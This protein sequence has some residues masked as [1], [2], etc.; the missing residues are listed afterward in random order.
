MITIPGKIEDNSFDEIS[1]YIYLI[2][3]ENRKHIA[4]D[5]SGSYKIGYSN[6]LH[7]RV[8]L[9][10]NEHQ[11]P[12]KVIAYGLS[13]NHIK[14][15]AH[16]HTLFKQHR[17]YGEY[18]D[19][20]GKDI[21][22]FIAEMSK[23]CTN[24]VILK[25]DTVCNDIENIKFQ[26]K[27]TNNRIVPATIGRDDRAVAVLS[28]HEKNLLYDQLNDAYK[29]RADFLMHTAV[30]IA[31]GY[32]LA[33]HPEC[34]RAENHAIF[35]PH[36]KG[37]GKERCTLKRRTILLSN[38]GIKAIE[39]FYFTKEVLP[40]YQSMEPVFKRAGRDAGFDTRYITTKMFRKTMI[41]WLMACYPEKQMSIA[42]SAG[43]TYL[44]MQGHYLTQGW[45]KED[46]RDMREEVNGWGEA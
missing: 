1:R 22:K 23:V 38:N 40:T 28:P 10:E 41:S 21:L 43:H 34:Y 37:L 11:V 6:N 15:E 42:L 14:A 3:I 35:L 20:D 4:N 16:L 36:V 27:I 9:L 39:A 8:S 13:K 45:R 12:V 26:N 33:G 5:K 44:T 30:R 18:F 2:K 31:E 17:R 46:V 29:K 19:F 7:N 24:V 25:D 32:Y